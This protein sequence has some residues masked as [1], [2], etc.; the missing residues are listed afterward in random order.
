M[1][2]KHVVPA[3]QSV[4]DPEGNA[5]RDN[6]ITNFTTLHLEGTAGVG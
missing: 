3:I 4:T 1:S 5:V 6:G 2:K